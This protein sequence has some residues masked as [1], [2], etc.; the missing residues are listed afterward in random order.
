MKYSALIASLQ[1][2]MGFF[3]L[4]AFFVGLLFNNYSPKAQLIYITYWMV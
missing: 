3:A 4:G 1:K 2:V